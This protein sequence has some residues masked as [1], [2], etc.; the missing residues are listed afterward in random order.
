[1]QFP[2]IVRSCRQLAAGIY[3]CDAARYAYASSCVHSIQTS[4]FNFN[5]HG[6]ESTATR[7]AP[8][9][10][11]HSSD[12][13]TGANSARMEEFFRNK[14][15]DRSEAII[16]SDSCRFPFSDSLRTACALKLE[17]QKCI[18]RGVMLYLPHYIL[19]IKYH[20]VFGHYVHMQ[21]SARA[22]LRSFASPCQ[23]L[24]LHWGRRQ[25]CIMQLVASTRH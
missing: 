8:L 10:G 7:H 20:N 13:A 9:R 18:V 17:C 1:M 25:L 4:K 3:P 14:I 19:A 12:I 6:M 16:R 11:A 15:S 23:P 24:Q 21:R 22:R 2:V 5:L